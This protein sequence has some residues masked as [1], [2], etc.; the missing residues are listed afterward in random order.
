[1]SGAAIHANG[2]RPEAKRKVLGTLDTKVPDAG[3][4][5]QDHYSHK[6][7]PWRYQLRQALLPVLRWETPYLKYMQEFCR[8]SF[9]DSYFALTAN[10]G[11][12]TFFMTALPIMFW[13]GYTNV[14]RA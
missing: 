13:C 3:L 2:I 6:L 9:L 12:H 4:K 5:D 10:L 14:G 11:T 8:T 7:S 1:M